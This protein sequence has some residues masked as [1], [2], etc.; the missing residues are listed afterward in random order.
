MNAHRALRV[1]SIGP[2]LLIFV[3]IP[4]LLRARCF[5]IKCVKTARSFTFFLGLFFVP[6]AFL[7]S[8]AKPIQTTQSF[9]YFCFNKTQP[10]FFYSELSLRCVNYSYSSFVGSD[11]LPRGMAAFTLKINKKFPLTQYSFLYGFI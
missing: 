2:K 3:Q 6:V 7:L 11:F 4:H 10:F 8:L 5:S 9:H 1:C